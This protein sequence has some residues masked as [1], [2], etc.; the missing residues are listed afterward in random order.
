MAT[1]SLTGL[2]ENGTNP[3]VGVITNPRVPIR[4]QVGASVVVNVAV[5]A[6]NGAQVALSNSYTFIMSCKLRP[7]DIPVAFAVTGTLSPNLGPNVVTFTIT[8]ANTQR[9]Q[10]GRWIYDVWQVDP[11][12]N[13]DAIIPLSPLLLEPSVT[14]YSAL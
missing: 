2:L 4:F 6:P 9:M 3:G 13:R 12:G 5:I 7:Q 8:P 1:I 11:S 10:P 14:P